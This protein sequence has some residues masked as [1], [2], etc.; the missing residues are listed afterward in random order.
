M[1]VCILPIVGIIVCLAGGS[2]GQYRNDGYRPMSKSDLKRENRNRQELGLPPIG[3]VVSVTPT[4][5]P[6]PRPGSI[7]AEVEK[8]RQM[9]EATPVG[10]TPVPTAIPT[11]ARDLQL[12]REKL[13]IEREKL[14]VMQE[15]LRLQQRS[16][17]TPRS[18]PSVSIVIED[19]VTTGGKK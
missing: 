14:R 3:H 19:V 2:S 17:A 13:E 11:Q 15:Q 10:E 7:A 8:R 1:R 4:P 16:A 6:T 9:L 5:P 12:E 18:A